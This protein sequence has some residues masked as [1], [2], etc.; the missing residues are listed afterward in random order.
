M[1]LC[2]NPIKS[3]AGFPFHHPDSNVSHWL[4]LYSF[5]EAMVDAYATSQS[6]V[7]KVVTN[8]A[9]ATMR[10]QLRVI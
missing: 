8:G 6:K 5:D 1:Q 4:P 2:Y 3:G 7:K 9:H 10:G